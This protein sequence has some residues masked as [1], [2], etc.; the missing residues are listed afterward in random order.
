MLYGIKPEEM[1]TPEARKKYEE[2]A[3]ITYL[4]K[5]DPAVIGWYAESGEPLKPGP[6]QGPNLYY[7]DFGKELAGYDNPGKGIHHPKF[8]VYLQDKM[9]ALGVDCEIK[10]R[11]DYPNAQN[12]GD[13]ADKDIVNFL[14]KHL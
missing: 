3:A 2:T 10:L 4:T 6:N 9:R 13:L 1:D 14:K 7:A 8:G 12:P 11:A 5:D